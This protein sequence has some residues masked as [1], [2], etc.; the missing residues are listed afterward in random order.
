MGRETQTIGKITIDP[1]EVW[2]FSNTCR[3]KSVYKNSVTQG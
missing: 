1:D 2:R 3:I